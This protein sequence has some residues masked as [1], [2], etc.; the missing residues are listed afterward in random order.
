MFGE[1]EEEIS[2]SVETVSRCLGSL[3]RRS[4]DPWKRFPEEQI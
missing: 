3:K 1:S 2:R 4:P